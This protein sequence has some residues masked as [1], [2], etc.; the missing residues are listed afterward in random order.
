MTDHI[1]DPR[2]LSALTRGNASA[3]APIVTVFESMMDK[4]LVEL[5]Q[6]LS[7]GDATRLGQLGHKAKSSAAS[8]GAQALA[9]RCHALETAMEAAT[10]DLNAAAHLVQEIQQLSPRVVQALRD[11]LARAS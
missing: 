5:Q 4:T 10:P 1:L 2:V 9:G 3:M 7:A 6:A 11:V 8:L